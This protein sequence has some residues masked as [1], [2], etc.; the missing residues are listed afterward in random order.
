MFK[1]WIFWR[2]TGSKFGFKGKTQCLGGLKSPF[3]NEM[4]QPML[5]SLWFSRTFLNIVR[6]MGFFFIREVRSFIFLEQ[7]SL[8]SSKFDFSKFGGFKIRK[9]VV[10]LNPIIL[11]WLNLYLHTLVKKSA[12]SCYFFPWKLLTF[13]DKRRPKDH[14][15][16]SKASRP[17]KRSFF[18]IKNDV[19]DEL[20]NDPSGEIIEENNGK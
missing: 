11:L 10:Q 20:Y 13:N 1:V 6:I 18:V 7:M 16:F 14:T 3:G 17:R 5:F 15:V 2:L 19:P 4:Y 8:A 9:I 12:A